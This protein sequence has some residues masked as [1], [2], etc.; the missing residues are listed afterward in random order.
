MSV[1]RARN[2]HLLKVFRTIYPHT[3]AIWSYPKRPLKV[4]IFK[5]LVEAHPTLDKKQ[6]KFFL[7]GYTSTRRY[8]GLIAKGV[9]RV[10]LAGNISGKITERERD[11]AISELNRRLHAAAPP[12]LEAAE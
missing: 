1:V 11:L 8:V 9:Y 4:G 2:D 7:R 12:S 6:L 5:D 10:D 3:F